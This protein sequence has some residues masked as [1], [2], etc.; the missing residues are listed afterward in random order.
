MSDDYC[1]LMDMPKAWCAHCRNATLPEL[2]RLHWF[3]SRYSGFCVDCG[4][5]YRRGDEIA[6]YEDG[7][8]CKGVHYA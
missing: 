3:E 8:L 4:R 7:Y 1:D 2:S 6:A 5:Q